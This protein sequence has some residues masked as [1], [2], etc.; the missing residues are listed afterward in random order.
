MMVAPPLL[1]TGIWLITKNQFYNLI[2]PAE[3]NINSLIQNV[4]GGIF[5]FDELGQIIKYFVNIL[6]D[7]K[8]WGSIGLGMIA[9]IILT[10]ISKP[11]DRKFNWFAWSIPIISILLMIGMYYVLSFDNLAGLDWWLTSGFYRMI[12]PGAVLLWLGIVRVLNAAAK[13]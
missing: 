1:L 4:S 11:K 12:M 7:I 8:I 5:H 2:D 10:L 9:A 3:S 6:F 13:E